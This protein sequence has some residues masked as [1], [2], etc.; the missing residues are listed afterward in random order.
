M[1]SSENYP[2]PRISFLIRLSTALKGL[3]GPSK[4]G[5]NGWWR[6]GALIWSVCGIY[7][8]AFSAVYH[9][10]AVEGDDSSGDGS[11]E[12]PYQTVATAL[13]RL[14]GGDELVLHDGNY[15]ALE[16]PNGQDLFSN[17]VE[18]RAADGTSPK[19]DRILISGASGPDSSGSYNAYLRFVGLHVLGQGIRASD[20][21]IASVRI[22]GPRHLEIRDCLIETDG[23]W[24]GSDANIEKTAVYIRSGSNITVSDCEITRTGT[25]MQ[26]RGQ[27]FKILR[28]HLHDLTHDGIRVMGLWNSLVEGNRIHGL[29]DGVN[30]GEADWNKHCD[31]IHIFIQGGAAENLQPNRNLVFRGNVIYDTESMG[32]QFNNY[33]P[34]PQIRNSDITFENNIL[35]PADAYNAF[36]LHVSEPVDNIIFRNNT[37][38]YVEGGTFYQSPNNETHR[39]LNC[40]SVRVAIGASSTGVQV[41]NNILYHGFDWP[42]STAV[43]WDRNLVMGWYGAG[44]VGGPNVI[45]V[46]ESPL[47][48]PLAF[49][50]ILKE[51]SVAIDAGMNPVYGLDIYGHVRDAKPDIGAV[52]VGGALN[53][54]PSFGF[55]SDKTMFEGAKLVL[56]VIATDG[57]H[58][59]LSLSAEGLPDWGF[60]TDLGNG[61]GELEF[62]PPIGV[63]GVFD[64]ILLSVT[65]GVVSDSMDFALTVLPVESSGSESVGRWGFNGNGDDVSGMGNN[66]VLQTG[67]TYS[68]DRREGSHALDLTGSAV[69]A[70][71][72]SDT[73][74]VSLTGDVTFAAYVRTE[75]AAT[76]T[77]LSKSFNDGYRFLIRDDQKLRLVLGR[78]G[79]GPHSVASA[80]SDGT[81]ALGKW[82][83]VAAT[84]KF[85][86]E[87]GEVRFYINGIFK[88]AKTVSIG[89]IEAG[90]GPLIIGAA[91]ES[92]DEPMRGLLDDVQIFRG[93]LTASEIAALV[94]ANLPPVLD[95]I[96]DVAVPIDGERVIDVVAFDSDGDD[97]SLAATG[98]PEFA[99]FTDNG[100]GTGTILFSPSLDDQ[101]TYHGLAVIARD[102]TGED[103]QGFSAVVSG[104]FWGGF[105]MQL[106]ERI[107][108]TDFIGP[109]YVQPSTNWVYA[110][111]L[112]IWVYFPE[113]SPEARGAWVYAARGK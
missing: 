56:K 86:G 7:T 93:A 46:R 103:I 105:P 47:V 34:H 64:D 20:N 79:S 16:F 92:G 2:C 73:D 78:P 66:S 33:G 74:T 102:S 97:I 63:S 69:G 82:Q 44:A 75:Q 40:Q 14:V 26:L 85:I 62:T 94:P 59:P 3:L 88:D 100:D 54:P 84:I 53:Q 76:Q 106:P 57:D 36:N 29:D 6:S 90:V 8:A 80:V 38:V 17:W 39:T 45:T 98:L 18:I 37:M 43:V 1:L 4:R 65:D 48:D 109:I 52:E 71:V 87:S 61:V 111:D 10:D 113:P 83:H 51:G 81:I 104:Q 50:G 72:V 108:V 11:L 30:D 25:G 55:L 27:D 67:A 31:G 22:Q 58:V 13:A 21:P 99:S 89:G 101:G 15:G 96:A 12:N 77:I 49:D 68:D 23:P 91:K 95:D 9:V 24:T 70:A 42:I 28:N 110:Y 5:L 35:G 41:Y 107:V 19:V 112:G 60:F 32:V